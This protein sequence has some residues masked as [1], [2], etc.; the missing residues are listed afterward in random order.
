MS[1][2]MK[3]ELMKV[4]RKIEVRINYAMWALKRMPTPHL[5]DVVMYKNEKCSL[6]QGVNNPY[7]NLLPLNNENLSKDIREIH[8]HVHVSEFK[9]EKTFKRNWWAFKSSYKFKMGYW[10]S[11]D[12]YGKKLFD[13]ISNIG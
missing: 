5:G 10:Y 11:I 13:P 7:W 2:A 8:K 1:K 6:I 4:L 9:L 12:T 3:E